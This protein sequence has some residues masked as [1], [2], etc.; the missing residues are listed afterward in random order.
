VKA[1]AFAEDVRHNARGFQAGDTARLL[2]GG[3]PAAKVFLE[4]LV[5]GGFL[6]RVPEPTA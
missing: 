4:E 6:Q 3:W 5:E 2:G 1:E